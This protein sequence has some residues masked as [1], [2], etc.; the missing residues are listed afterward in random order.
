MNDLKITKGEWSTSGK[1]CYVT[2]EGMC[3]NIDTSSKEKTLA[4]AKLI[5]ASPAL[6]DACMSVIKWA[7]DSGYYNDFNKV[8]LAI[9]KATK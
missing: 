9:K 3:I 6:L 2:G 4:N 7:D 8:R 1:S 5:A